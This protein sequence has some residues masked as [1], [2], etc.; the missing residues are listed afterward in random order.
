VLK[1]A[2]ILDPKFKRASGPVQDGQMILSVP[3]GADGQFWRLRA[4]QMEK[5]AEVQLEGIPAYASFHRD[6][7]FE[8]G[9]RGMK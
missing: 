6:L 8:M 4:V 7:W 5:N 1:N 9:S 2:D 3:D